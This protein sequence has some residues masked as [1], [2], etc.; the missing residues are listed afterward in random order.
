MKKIICLLTVAAI[1]LA[2]G[3]GCG[4]KQDGRTDGGTD[5][6]GGR[7]NLFTWEGMFPQET[8]DAFEKDTG[9]EVN[10]VNFDTD[11][12]MLAKLETAKGGDY[13]LVIA[14]DYILEAA[15][16]Q[17][18]AKKIDKSRLSNYGNLNPIYLKQFFDPDDEYTVP[19]GAGVQTIV[20]DPSAVGIDIQGYGDLWDESLRDNVGVIANYRVIDGMALKTLGESYNTNDLSKI[21]KAGDLLLKLAP[22]IRII[23]DDD[24]QE[25]ILSGEIAAGVFYTNQALMA[26]TAK[27]DLKMVFP[28]EGIGFGVFSSFIPINAPN[29]DAAYAFIDYILEGETAARCYEYLSYYSV[30][31]AADEYLSEDLRPL[32]TLPEGFNI[33]MEKIENVDV[34]ADELHNKIW[35]EF[36]TACGQM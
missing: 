34:E 12:T 8:L 7:L 30:N 14:D 32:L 3:V 4:P 25:D 26:V 9:Y 29:P 33:D 18:L 13:D 6:P 20:Y 1:A 36:Q 10:Y 22:N 24:L 28:K 16:K 35:T 27:P 11:E 2:S 15:I 31:A 19:Y 5:K 21:Q 23:K 17:G